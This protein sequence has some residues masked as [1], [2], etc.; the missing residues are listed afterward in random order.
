MNKIL[1][2]AKINHN[3]IEG[4]RVDLVLRETPNGYHKFTWY[5]LYNGEENDTEV[6][7]GTIDQ[8]NENAGFAWVAG[9]WNLEWIDD[10]DSEQP[11]TLDA[12]LEQIKSGALDNLDGN[13]WA[14]LPIFG[15]TTPID[16]QGVWS[17]DAKRLL[18][19]TCKDDMKIV[20]R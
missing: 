17:W 7:G 14:E 3:D 2:R 20:S 1:S 19:G 11:E 4:V 10:D 18:I 12:L 6:G 9:C 5:S 15:G 16:T 13:A 8:A